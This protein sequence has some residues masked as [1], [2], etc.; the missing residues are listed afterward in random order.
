M[1]DAALVSALCEETTCPICL[2]S[3]REPVTVDC[4][5][6]FCRGCIL[7]YWEDF[8]KATSCPQC[9]EI[10]QRR[11]FRT[12]R[13][14]ANV[15]E[16]VKKL[17]ERTRAEQK[18]GLC[19]RHREPRK[20]FCEEEE[21]E[22]EEALLCLACGA[23]EEHHDRRAVPAEEV[24]PKDKARLEMEKQKITLTFEQMHTFLQE[25]EHLRLVQLKD[26]MKEIK[27]R[28]GENGGSL[29]EEICHLSHLIRKMERKFQQECQ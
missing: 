21:E 18:R 27:E 4:G 10:I 12:N 9:R 1:A 7:H 28:Q 22:E 19:R 17:E 13:Q 29:S 23:A 25:K 20:L 16:I 14:L 15:I 26:L 2:E 11:K 6:N 5:H 8:S 3:F 24:A